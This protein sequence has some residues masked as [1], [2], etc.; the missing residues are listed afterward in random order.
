[1]KDAG[2]IAMGK[3]E[4]AVAMGYKNSQQLFRQVNRCELLMAKLR[5]VDYNPFAKILTPIQVELICKH[6]CFTKEEIL[7]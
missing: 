5:E 3:Q 1:M 2:W 4:L 6:F 7:P